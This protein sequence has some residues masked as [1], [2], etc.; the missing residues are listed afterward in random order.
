MR[1]PLIYEDHGTVNH[2][3]HFVDP[4]SGVHTQRVEGWWG[5]CKSDFRRMNGVPRERLATHLDE[6]L[7]RQFSGDNALEKIT[8]LFEHLAAWYPVN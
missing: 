1:G 6:F 7:Y 2:E 5:T 3:E 8:H 4:V